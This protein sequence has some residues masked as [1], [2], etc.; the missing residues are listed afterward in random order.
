[1]IPQDTVNKI[2][3]S[4]QIV[5]VV[6]DFVSLKRRGANFI[7]CCPFH[8][9]KTPSFY[10]SPAKGIYKCFGC[11]K[12]GTAVGFVMEHENM[13]YVEAL[14]YL[15]RKYGIEVK[16]K[17]ETPEEIAARQR[18]ESL[19]LVLDYTEQF[20]QKSLDTPEGKSIG[21]AYFRSRGLEDA[22]I[23]KYGLGW[24][25]KAGNALAAEALS[26]GYK[27]EFLTTTGVCIK[28]HDGSLCDKFYDRVIFPIHSVS[29]RVLGFGGRTLRSDYKTANIGKYV[30]SPQSEVYDKSSTLYGI[31]FAKSEIVRQN[32]CYLV[33]GYLD[34]LSMHQLG[35]TNVVASSGT[36]LTIPQIRL[37]KKFTDNVTVM[38]DGDSAGIHA[39]LRGI[40]LILKEGLNVRV[41]LIPDGDDPDSYS[42][43][44]SLEDV[45][46][47]LKSAEKDFIV[48]KTD[49]LLGQAGDDP[50]NKA[51]LINDIT[52]T[53]ALVPD[54]IKRAVYVQ[55]TSQKFGISEDAIYS[56]I[57]D[58]RQKMLEN[59]RKEAE[60]ERMR[61]EREEAR[62][63]ANVAEAN[64]GTP[65]EPLPVDYGEPVDGID[66]GYIPEGYL[67]PEE[68]GEPA[69]EAPETPKVTSEEGILME[70]P[71]MAPSEKELLVL[72]LKYGL[73]TL[74]FE[75]DSEYYDKNEKFTVA[76]FIRDAIDGR[77]FANT[78]YRKTYNEYF[79]L[80][81]GDATLTQ[82]DIIRKIMDGPD[83]VMATLTGDLTQDKYLLTVKNFADSMTSLSSFLVINVPRAI[84]VYNSKIVRMQEIEISEKLNAMKHGEC[85]EEE[86]MALLEKF[87]KT[88]ALRK[89]ITERLGRVQ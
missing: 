76:D 71:V 14:K 5:D 22:T 2:L 86:M 23:R 43:K 55:M 46:S 30:N 8:N 82:D 50:L 13:T 17:E 4:A 7:A 53:L 61:A 67:P 54:Q 89:K 12:S 36:S 58:T 45:Q 34:V 37:I 60:R 21:Y 44:H 33:E 39:A 27:E 19:L 11:G 57:T 75:T 81:D 78:V 29:G 64:A 72:I 42:R 77:E 15:A 88:A 52:D 68:V 28:R 3:D 32:K 18:S 49:L 73:E 41:V 62:V 56:R 16:E 74:D 59:E 84:L 51:G 47:F 63:N 10:V 70:N 31:Y 20:F 48:F 66:G 40:D 65:S 26:K 1:M 25:P 85:P 69:A 83:R 80:Y 35:I 38:Y 6:S 87:Q 79:R 24:A 9:E